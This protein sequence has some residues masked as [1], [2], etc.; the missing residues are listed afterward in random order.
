MTAEAVLV[1][2]LLPTYA[3][4]LTSAAFSVVFRLRECTLDTVRIAG[5][6]R[7]SVTTDE[8]VSI[9]AQE[10]ILRRWAEANGGDIQ[11]FTDDGYSGSKDI[12]RPAYLRMVGEVQAGMFDVIL[13][14]SLDRLGRR[15]RDFVELADDASRV[16][17]RI[18]AIESGLDTGTPTGRMMLSLLST[19]AEFEAAQIGQRQAVSQA[20]RRKEGRATSGAGMGF[21]H[22]KRDDGTYREI[23][24]ESAALVREIA[25]RVIGGD[26]LRA[27]AL[28]LNAEGRLTTRGNRWTAAQ[29]TQLLRNPS[30]AGQRKHRDDVERG[31]DGLPVVDTH[32]QIITTEEWVALQAA[33]DARAVNRM[34]GPASERLLLQ[35]LA[36]CSGCGRALHRSTSTEQGA[37]VIKYVCSGRIRK[38]CP[39]PVTIRASVL[40]DYVVQAL[41]PLLDL[42]AV[43]YTVVQDAQAI[44]RRALIGAEIR[45]LA[46]GLPGA[47][48]DEMV[49]IAQRIA[50]LTALSEGIEVGSTVEAIDTGVT[51]RERFE[52]DPRWVIEQAIEQVEVRR[53][54][55]G[56]ERVV[57]VWRESGEWAD[58]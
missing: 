16:G 56:R 42:P 48:V 25:L 23:E 10:A 37:K 53:A 44:E 9:A 57:I 31:P 4:R 7:L 5:Y 40:D 6:A 41:E 32:L 22:V 34:H 12:E 1:P 33:L 11:M 15:L 35:G 47:P 21:R 14:K 17:C 20:Y 29:V 26:S 24:P 8:S 54:E 30:I 55:R 43:E 28:W 50:E 46:T 2:L 58:D 49:G 18:L 39:S 13:V 45:A 38:E 52:Q 27:T 3:G 36:T 19:F 51:F